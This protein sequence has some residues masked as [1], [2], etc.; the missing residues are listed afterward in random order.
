MDLTLHDSTVNA[1]QDREIVATVRREGARLREFIRRRV[2]DAADAEDVLQDVLFEFVAAQR[3][4]RPIEHAGAWLLRV[5]RNRII[6]RFRRKRPEVSAGLAASP[7]QEHEMPDESALT[8]LLPDLAAGPEGELLRAMLW[9]QIEEALNEL[10]ATQREV[11]IAHELEGA[12]Y[13]EMAARWGVNLN[14]LLS[15][16]RAAVAAL[17]ERLQAL[18][19]DWLNE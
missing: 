7:G 15:R 12:S 14:T 13:N 6:D 17:R 8:E 2:L 10:P 9:E 3:L 18:Y 4:L 16:K 5:A 19:D 1:D 11:F